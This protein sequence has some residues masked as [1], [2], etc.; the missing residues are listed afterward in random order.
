VSKI[1]DAM[2][3][4]EGEFWRPEA[5][6]PEAPSA[7]P[8]NEGPLGLVPPLAGEVLQYYESVGKQIELTL[9]K[10]PHKTLLFTGAIAGD[11]ISTVLAQ[12]GEMLSRRG[13]RVLLIDG[14][15]RRPALHRHFH[16]PDSPGLA[17]YVA[18][19]ASAENV[20]HPTGFANLGMVPLGRCSDR[21]EAER[22]IEGLGDFQKVVADQ[23]D[24]VLVDSDY[25]GSAFFSQ[26]AVSNADGVV[27]VIR[28]GKTNR[29]IAARALETVKHVQ[30]RVLG[31]ILN[32][33]EF[34]IPNFIYRRL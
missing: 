1:R 6:R 10:L 19:T 12:Y 4:S 25:I 7:A 27:L 11:G 21:S 17:E 24:Y 34:P 23:Y 3:K 9:G 22:I 26:S 18:G 32:R 5:S 20:I 16:L 14:N 13:E 30:G 8:R 33:R 2:R 29:Q 31:V 15:P 28:A